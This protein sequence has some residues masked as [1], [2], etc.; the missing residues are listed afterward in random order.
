MGVTEWFRGIFRFPLSIFEFSHEFKE[1][2]DP[3]GVFSTISAGP[4]SYAICQSGCNALVV[5]CYA[6]AGFV[7]GTLTAGAGIPAALAGCNSALGVCM[8][9]YVA[10]GCLPIP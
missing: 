5:S 10:A 4:V 3:I 8:A 6:S 1:N 7:F 9:S 2:F